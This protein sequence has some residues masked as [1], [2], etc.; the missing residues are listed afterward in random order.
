MNPLLQSFLGGSLIGLASVLL[1]LFNGRISGISGIFSGAIFFKKNDFIWRYCFLAGLIL[2]PI[3]L[4]FFGFSYKVSVGGNLFLIILA[5]FLVG[6]G[7]NLSG[8]CTSGHGVCGI[9]RLSKRSF[10]S[11]ICFM[12]FAIVT[13]TI[14][15]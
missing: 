14:L 7:T 10:I 11:T 5:G 4:K 2:S 1:M 9:S 6:F 15:H 3:I 13:A 12:F 8:G